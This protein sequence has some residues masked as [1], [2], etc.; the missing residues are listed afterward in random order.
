MQITIELTAEEQS[1]LDQVAA[2]SEQDT[3]EF[4]RSTVKDSISDLIQ[5]SDRMEFRRALDW[6]LKEH[7]EVLLRLAK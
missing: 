3:A 6:V 4:I 5:H 1:H 2:S 7:H